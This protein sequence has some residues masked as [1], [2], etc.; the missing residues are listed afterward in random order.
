MPQP[1][2]VRALWDLQRTLRPRETRPDLRAQTSRAKAALYAA[3]TELGILRQAE[4]FTPDGRLLLDR[5][6]L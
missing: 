3:A 2:D 4:R 5:E 6:A 1:D